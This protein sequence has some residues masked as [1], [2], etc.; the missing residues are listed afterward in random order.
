[1]SAGPDELLL[2][3]HDASYYA[4]KV[5]TL[6]GVKG[7]AW[8]SVVQPIISPKPE[9]VALTGA[10]QR[11]PV[12]QV[13]ADVYCDSSLVMREL[14]RRAPSPRALLGADLAVDEW[15]DRAVAQLCFGIT[16]AEIGHRTSEAFS[17]D[18]AL[19]YGGSMDPDAVAAAAPAIRAQWRAR[20]EM[21]DAALDGRA[22]LGGNAPS[23][24]DCAAYIPFWF[25]D[26]RAF[27]AAAIDDPAQ[28]A[29]TPPA[30]ILERPA[31]DPAERLLRGLARVHAWR[32]R[33]AGIGHGERSELSRVDAL[34]TALASEP[35]APVEHDPEDPLGLEPG[36]PVTVR[37]DDDLR[38]ATPGTLVGLSAAR[39]VI[40]REAPEVGRVHVHFP[41]ARFEVAPA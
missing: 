30:P 41:R 5:R 14:E 6:F 16:F 11:V 13:G 10:Y 3:H 38:D 37:A 18:R 17:A 19:I 32:I 34:A 9:Y 20:A 12:L 28:P 27:I 33:M 24:A 36:T 4:E 2:H 1:M 15:S 22:F 8:R 31:D 40:A 25:Y 35:A 26:Q 39:V 21:L 23:L 7:L 29:D